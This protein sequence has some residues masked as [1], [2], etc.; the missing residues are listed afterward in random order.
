M[1]VETSATAPAVAEQ[2]PERS[3][4]S[5][6]QKKILCFIP[7]LGSGGAEMH[8]LR[9]LN[10]LDRSAFEPALAVVRSGGSYETSLRSDIPILQCGWDF[11]PSALLRMQTTI[12]HLRRIL[13]SERPDVVVA[14][15]DH[16]VA[17]T[18]KALTGMST[19]RPAFI[20]GIQ[21]NLEKTLEHL[22]FWARGWLRPDILCGYTRADCVIALS[23]GVAETLVEQLPTILKRVVVIPNAGYDRG[24]ERLALEA[25]AISVPKG[26]WFLGCGRLTAQ[27]DFL[28]LLRAFARIKDETGAELWI[29]GEG[30][31]RPKLEREIATLHLESSVRLPG[32]VQ[33]PFAFMARASAFVLSSR[34]E[35]FGNVLTEAMA[36][37]TPVISTDCPHGP[38]EILQGGRWGELVAVADVA[39]LAQA[40][41]R[42]LR[43]RALVQV[44]AAA[45]R[46]YVTRFE[47]NE[48][49]PQYEAAFR[50]ALQAKARLSL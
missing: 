10:H 20:A 40:M 39:A 9:L 33:N 42:S 46:D 14:F 2:V 23:S 32:F 5:R 27:K 3:A 35:G 24:V 8:L 48:I 45:A 38:G 12:P 19:P 29:L 50:A 47:A 41:R 16:A 15:L 4:L 25:P 13:E 18:A 34:W 21:N 43:E 30:E 37:G 26:P 11:L 7:H 44:R 36:C 31:A 17:A 28:T 22:P 49:T 6:E 1:L